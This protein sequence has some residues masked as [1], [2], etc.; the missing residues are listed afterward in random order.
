MN[1][2]TAFYLAKDSSASSVPED[3]ASC[4]CGDIFF[5][6]KLWLIGDP[7]FKAVTWRKAEKVQDLSRDCSQREVCWCRLLIF[8]S[9]V[10]GGD[11]EPVHFIGRS[12]KKPRENLLCTNIELEEEFPSKFFFLKTQDVSECFSYALSYELLFL[13]SEN[14]LFGSV[15]WELPISDGERKIVLLIKLAACLS[16]PLTHTH[17]HARSHTGKERWGWKAYHQSQ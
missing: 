5:F 1:H 10:G 3:W 15:C 8:C 16:L 11:K 14:N 17:T 7:P 9:S 6:W 13:F 2:L 4:M 12:E